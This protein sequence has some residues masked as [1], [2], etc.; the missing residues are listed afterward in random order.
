MPVTFKSVVRDAVAWGLERAGLSDPSRRRGELTIATFHR[1][2]PAELRDGYPYFGLAVTPE[3]LDFFLTFFRD[4]YTC[5]PLAPIWA[6]H[7]AGE[8]PTRPL[9]ALTFDDGQH[10]NLAYAAPVLRRHGLGASF[11]LPSDL[12]S[13]GQLIWHDRVGF[14]LQALGE[15]GATIEGRAEAMKALSPEQRESEAD[16]LLRMSGARV[17]RW[18]GLMSWDDARRLVAE[19]H[20]IGSHSLRHPLLP[21]CDDARLR[22]EFEDSKAAIEA[23]IDRPVETF[24]Y[25]NGD[26][27]ERVAAAAERAGYRC[28][29]TTE[30]GTNGPGQS[31]FLLRRCDMHPVHSRGSDGLLSPARLQLRISPPRLR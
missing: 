4:R 29:V 22:A 10:D 18:A 12:V 14:A 2:L 19:G 8:R 20:E 31:P 17:P 16:Q 6:R 13:A 21:Q 1:V 5:G 25:P 7:A 23:Q 26:A 9:L 24:C 27:D 15:S 28:A 30:W 3:E 11:Y